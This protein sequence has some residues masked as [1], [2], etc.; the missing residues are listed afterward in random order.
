LGHESL[1]R[2]FSLKKGR[3]K[4]NKKKSKKKKVNTSEYMIKDGGTHEEPSTPAK[5]PYV[6]TKKPFVRPCLQKK[7]PH[8]SRKRNLY[9]RK[10]GPVSLQKSPNTPQH[11]GVG[12]ETRRGCFYMS[13]TEH[14]ISTK[15]SY[16]SAKEPYMSAKEP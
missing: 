1:N 6:S 9:L 4:G 8:I 16:I 5:E 3:K 7:A 12:R 10:Q 11:T 2:G 15:E 14:C 13:A